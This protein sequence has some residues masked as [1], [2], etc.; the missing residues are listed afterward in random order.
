MKLERQ[1]T[2]A[3]PLGRAWQTDG[4]TSGVYVTI[5]PGIQP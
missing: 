3:A 2:V 4:V 5:L 1:F